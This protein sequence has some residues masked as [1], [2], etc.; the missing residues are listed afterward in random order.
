MKAGLRISFASPSNERYTFGTMSSQDRI[1]S[2]M[3][4]RTAKVLLAELLR[5]LHGLLRPQAQ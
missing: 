2:R 5:H 3:G 1:L 4:S